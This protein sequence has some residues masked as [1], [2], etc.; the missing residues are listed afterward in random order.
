MFLAD[1]NAHILLVTLNKQG[2]AANH[3]YVDHW[4]DEQLFHWQSQSSTTPESKRGRELIHHEELG[5][6]IHLFV[7]EN[8]LF[9][10]KA[11]PFTY[12]GKMDYQSHEG[13]R[14]MSVILKRA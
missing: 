10:K 3:R 9:N 2:K 13:S 14:P 8:K 11:A 6:T 12:Y 5:L 1:A 7:R 4:I